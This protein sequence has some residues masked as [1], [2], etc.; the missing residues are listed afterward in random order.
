[1]QGP[2]DFETVNRG[3]VRMVQGGQEA[4]FPLQP[5]DAV[6]IVGQGTRQHL[7]GHLPVEA[8]VERTVDLT[9]AT[10]IERPDDAIRP[11]LG[12]RG[13]RGRFAV[14]RRGCVRQ[15]PVDRGT[16]DKRSRIGVRGEQRLHF[17]PERDVLAARVA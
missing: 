4:A 5:G 9:H 17:S 8:G 16:L 3:D 2:G 15:Q 12:S 7:D 10:R 13:H 14:H 1:M 11:D 6:R